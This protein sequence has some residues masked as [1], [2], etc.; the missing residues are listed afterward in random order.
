MFTGI[1]SAMTDISNIPPPVAV[2]AV[3]AEV[4]KARIISATSV[5]MENSAMTITLCF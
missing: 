3:K 5:P 2:T 1:K 4:K